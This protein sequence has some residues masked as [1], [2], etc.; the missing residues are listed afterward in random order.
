MYVYVYVCVVPVK[1]FV[2][3]SDAISDESYGFIGKVSVGVEKR[4]LLKAAP[5]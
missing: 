3:I 1:I 2:A 4:I 5:C